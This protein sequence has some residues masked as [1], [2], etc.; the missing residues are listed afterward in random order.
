[1]EIIFIYNEKLSAPILNF[2]HFP[3]KRIPTD[4]ITNKQANSY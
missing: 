3:Q 2:E 4:T 1:M